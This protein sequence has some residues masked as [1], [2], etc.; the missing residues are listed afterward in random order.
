MGGGRLDGNMFKGNWVL[1]LL[2][3]KGDDDL[4]CRIYDASYEWVEGVQER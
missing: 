3:W 2:A 1:W 4:S